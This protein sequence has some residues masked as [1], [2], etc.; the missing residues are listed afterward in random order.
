MNR[1]LAIALAVLIAVGVPTTARAQ[2]AEE[3]RREFQAIVDGLNDNT[4]RGFHDAI[5]DK[6][7]L[8]RVFGTRVIEEEARDALAQSFTEAVEELFVGSFPPSR[9]VA[10]GGDITGTVIAFDA[11]GGEGRAVVRYESRGYRYTYHAYDLS[12]GR[13]GKV[14]IVDWYDYYR[15]KR[16]SEEVGNELVRAM[17]G[18]NPVAG[19]LEQGKPTEAQLFQTGELLKT[20]RDRNWERYFQIHEGLEESLRNEPYIVDQHHRIC[21]DIAATFNFRADSASQAQVS[22]E[23][24]VQAQ[25]LAQAAARA[26]A[27]LD[28]AVDE[29]VARFPGDARYSLSLAHHYVLRGRY[30]DAIAEYARFQDAL[31]IKDGASES[32]K[33]TAAMALGDFV[34]AQEYAL[35]AT[36]VE[37]ALELAWWTLLRTRTAGRDYAGATEALTEL[38]ERFGHLLIPQTLRRDRFL[39]VLIEQQEYRD[40]RAQRDAA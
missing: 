1:V 7:F 29:L 30:A 8:N 21:I 12:F 18:R 37:P 9:R 23:D 22:D 24:R 39:R 3:A 5:D 26:D 10:H 2:S 28:A 36:E 17:P 32:I 20:V 19:I 31:G 34:K 6:S 15:G 38:E 33:A 35:S 13:G 40:W 16:F 27:R 25:G 11:N 14:T 4:F